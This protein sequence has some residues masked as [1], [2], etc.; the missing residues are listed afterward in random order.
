MRADIEVIV[1]RDIE[2][3]CIGIMLGQSGVLQSSEIRMLL[4]SSLVL[5][6]IRAP[7]IGPF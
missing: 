6:G 7:I 2:Y 5:Y 3:C 4:R 1:Q